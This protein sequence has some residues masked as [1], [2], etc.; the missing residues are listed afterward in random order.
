MYDN[1]TDR[2]TLVA[3]FATPICLAVGIACVFAISG[4]EASGVKFSSAAWPV[5]LA[6]LIQWIAFVPSYILRTEKYYD[7]VGGLTFISVSIVALALAPDRGPKELVLFAFVVIW[8]S[9]LS[10][11]L[12]LRIHRT[13]TDRRFAEIKQSFPKFLFAWRLRTR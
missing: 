5:V 8:A 2:S 6:F 12:F 11:F 9:R 13:K 7:L 1:Q 3:W 10:L 4:A